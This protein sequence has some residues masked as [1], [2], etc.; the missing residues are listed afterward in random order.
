MIPIDPALANMA[1]PYLTQVQTRP[2]CTCYM[3]KTDVSYLREVQQRRLNALPSRLRPFT[4]RSREL[5]RGL[6]L[7]GARGV[8]KTT[9]LLHHAR[10]KEM[11]YISA[12]NPRVA[13]VSLYDAGRTA[14][15]SGYAGMIVDEVHFA[16]EWSVHAKALYDDFPDRVLWLSDSSSLILRSAV[17]DVSRRFVSLTMPLL[18]FRE[19]L[20]LT[21]ERQYP[22]FDAF[23]P[24]PLSADASLLRS[25]AEYRSYGTRPFFREGH[26][27][28]RLQEVINKTIHYDIPFLLPSVTEGNLRLMNAVIGTLAHA[29]IPR[30][31][32]RSLCADWAIG[33]EKL[34]QLL[35]A[36]ESVGL[37]TIVRQQNDRKA[38]S[39][40]EKLFFGDPTM[41]AVLGGE[42]GNAREALVVSLL[43]Q[44][45]H[46]VETT[47]DDS[48]GDFVVDGS[49]TIEVG[50][51]SKK[52]KSADF[53][54]RDDLDVPAG[55]AIPLWALGFGY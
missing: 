14:F 9:F 39:V 28:E 6:L 18:S 2:Y 31:H 55:N 32:V 19:F 4:A 11:L 29:S 12:D 40:G 45:G 47:R 34:Y 53:V 35:F 16:R 30:L 24:I 7:T 54:V 26:Y 49:T 38:K 8:G 25:F 41:Y 37:L 13:D 44:S 3:D 52:A 48:T 43:K 23:G 33:S 10:E 22:T 15:L 36:M 5:P 20:A 1:T 50:G 21:Q 42:A 27:T 46:T 17:A 51:R